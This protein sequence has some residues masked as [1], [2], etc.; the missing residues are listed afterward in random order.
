MAFYA[1][2]KIKAANLGQLTTTAQYQ[3]TSNQTITSAS[4][5]F[6][7]LS[8]INRSSSLVTR[9]TSGSGHVFTLNASGL[10]SFTST[11]R[12]AAQAN[13]SRESWLQI[14]AERLCACAQAGSASSPSTLSLSI[15]EWFDEGD[16]I[17][18]GVY[19]DSGSNATL[20]ANAT[21]AEG[22]LDLAY[23]LGEV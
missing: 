3:A 13:G 14:G 23:L 6:V 11:V 7:L 1:G 10:W 12:F 16:Q 18:V 9:A 15:T 4:Q 21:N 22:R 20:V 19:Q 5:G 2:Q 17:A 8:G